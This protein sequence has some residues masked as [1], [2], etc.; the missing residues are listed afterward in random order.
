MK[1]LCKK[2]IFLMWGDEKGPLHCFKEDQAAIAAF[3]S[4]CFF[5]FAGSPVNVMPA[6]S[7]AHVK[8]GKCPGPDLTV[9]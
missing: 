8:T 2:M 5:V 9:V 3:F 7:T 1:G 6:S 4:A